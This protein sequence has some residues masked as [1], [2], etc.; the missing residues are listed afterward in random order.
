[1]KKPEWWTDTPLQKKLKEQEQNNQYTQVYFEKNEDS[2]SSIYEK[3]SGGYL[4]MPK[5]MAG[6]DLWQLRKSLEKEYRELESGR[7]ELEVKA[8][9]AD[10]DFTQTKL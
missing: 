8:R 4:T 5:G 10:I 9:G 3:F 7:G 1:M 2:L 6:C